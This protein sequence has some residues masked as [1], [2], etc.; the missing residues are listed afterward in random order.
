MAIRR[1]NDLDGIQVKWL[2]NKGDAP[3]FDPNK[4]QLITRFD[5]DYIGIDGSV[6]NYN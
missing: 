2:K 6:F 4:L 3:V 1:L 5:D